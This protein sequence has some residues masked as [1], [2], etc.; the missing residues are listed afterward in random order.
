ML[1][2][3]ISNHEIKLLR[4]E[5][6]KI[7]EEKIIKLHDLENYILAPFSFAIRDANFMS[8][9]QTIAQEILKVFSLKSSILNN[10]TH[11]TMEEMSA[12]ILTS[13]TDYFQDI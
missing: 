10:L 2:V 1:I 9:V 3:I 7:S 11:I 6:Y 5:K 8:I 12:K 13:F 4:V